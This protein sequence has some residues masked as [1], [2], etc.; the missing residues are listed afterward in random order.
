[1]IVVVVLL[2]VVLQQL[3]CCQ[4]CSCSFRCC[5][6]EMKLKQW[7]FVGSG[8]RSQQ[9]WCC[10]GDHEC[11]EVSGLEMVDVYWCTPHHAGSHICNCVYNGSQM[12]YA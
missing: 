5:L 12:A 2:L 7:D 11:I 9:A 6:Q 1:M 3:L 8:S 10:C 4:C